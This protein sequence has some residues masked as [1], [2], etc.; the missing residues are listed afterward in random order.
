MPP[1]IYDESLLTAEDTYRSIGRFIFEF[2]Q[3][4]YTIRHYLGEEIGI[5]E[6]YFSSVIESYDVGA[7]CNV[8][9]R[10]FDLREDQSAAEIK[11]LI[12]KFQKLKDERNRIAHGL[13]VPFK[14]G[15]TVHYTSRNSLKLKTFNE[16]ATNLGQLADRA[17]SLRA[18]LERVFTSIPRLP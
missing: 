16:Q 3:A 11:K 8:A 17:C 13:W 4:E 14:D 10:V 2:S 12:N 7:L 18:E 6:K 1:L 5:S 9:L 15:G